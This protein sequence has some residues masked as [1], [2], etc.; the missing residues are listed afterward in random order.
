MLLDISRLKKLGWRPKHNSIE[1][2]RIAV[3]EIL[4]EIEYHQ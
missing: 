2:V 4:K 3:K 1:S